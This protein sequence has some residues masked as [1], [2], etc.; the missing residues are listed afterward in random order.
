MS[1][2]L[3]D[4]HRQA[5]PHYDLCA[6]R[7]SLSYSDINGGAAVPLFVTEISG[8]LKEKEVQKKPWISPI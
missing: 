7:A 8:I 3:S 2:H 6:I 5:A 4:I 1:H